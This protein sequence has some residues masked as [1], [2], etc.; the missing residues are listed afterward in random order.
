MPLPGNTS[1]VTVAGTFLNPDGDPAT[2][3]ITFTPSTWL[4]NSVDNITIP[5]ATVTKTLG[6]AGNFTAVLPVTDDPDLSPNGWRYEVA[7]V[8]DDVT[9]RYDVLIPAAAATAGTV[10][11]ADLAPAT[12]AGPAYYSLASSLT[13][14]TVSVLPAGSAATAAI[15]GLAP[16]QT[17]DLGI[18]TGPQGATGPQGPQGSVGPQG[19]QGATGPQGSAATVTVGTV[20]SVAYPGPGTVT[21]SGTS[22]SAVLDFILVTGPQGVEGTLSAAGLAAA[23]SAVAAAGSADASAVAAAASAGS[24]SSSASAAAAS[25]G[26]ADTSA[27]NASTSATNALGYLGSMRAL[28][29]QFYA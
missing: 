6:T 22:G 25:A 17:L 14:G 28:T 9:R 3:T 11:L 26:S 18:P 16:N 1:T 20:G 10:W 4:T 24:A 29:S 8:V 7:E 2:G 21:N 12:V 19:S 5:A 15:T 13:I 23:G 27:S